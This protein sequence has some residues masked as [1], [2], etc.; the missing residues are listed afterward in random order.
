MPAL[1]RPSAEEVAMGPQAAIEVCYPLHSVT[2]DGRPVG[3]G[4]AVAVLEHIEQ[5]THWW[6]V[7]YEIEP[8]DLDTLAQE[9]EVRATTR[10]GSVLSGRAVS[11]CSSPSSRYIGLR[12]T[13]TLLAA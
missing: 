8:A 10:E 9:V 12:G 4:V 2:I 1:Q 13:G 11:V 6:L 5:I 7:I 3:C